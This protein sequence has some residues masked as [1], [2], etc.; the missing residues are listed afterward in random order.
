MRKT[1]LPLLCAALSALATEHNV[2]K[3][4]EVS[5]RPQDLPKKTAS[6]KALNRVTDELKDI[7]IEYVDVNP[8]AERTILMVHGWPSLWHSWKYQIEQFKNDYHLVVPNIRGF[9]GSGHPDDV[10]SSGNWADIVGDLVC[11]LE[12]AGVENAICLGHDW[13]SQL[14]FQAARQRPDKITAV[15]GAAVPYLP[16][17]SPTFSPVSALVPYFPHLAYQVFLGETPDLA[18]VELD[19]DIRRT[20]RATL[21]TTVDPPPKAFLT[22]T[23]DFLGAWDGV[24][25]IGSIPFFTPDEEDYWVEQYSKQGFKNTLQFYTPENQKG[26]WEFIRD[27]GNYTIPQPVLSILPESDPVADWAKVYK[28]LGSADFL[29]NSDLQL[30][31][32]GHWLHLEHPATFNYF[33]KKWLQGLPKKLESSASA[34][35]VKKAEETEAHARPND[36]L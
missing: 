4:L 3:S 14:C 7:D 27:Q 31:P 30:M 28:L 29:P 15:I 6:C 17:N 22:S 36:E 13:G 16:T 19:A 25:E 24:K 11:V 32:G 8:D 26:S 23:K 10:R 9:G 34:T 12:H 20:L 5:F 21:R 18:R 1:F 35:E 33:V 2:D